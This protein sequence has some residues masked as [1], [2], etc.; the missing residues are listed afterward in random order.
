[1]T[2]VILGIDALDWRLVEDFSCEGLKLNHNR[3]LE[4]FSHSE[5]VPLTGEVWPSIAIGKH[6]TEHSSDFVGGTEWSSPVLNKLS[7]IFQ[8]IMPLSLRIKIGKIIEST[9]NEDWKYDR[10]EMTEELDGHVFSKDGRFVENWPGIHRTEELEQIWNYFTELNKGNLSGTHFKGLVMS[11]TRGQ[12]T[13][14]K[15]MSNYPTELVATHLHMIDAIG[16]YHNSDRN[17][18]R[19]AYRKCEKYVNEL[20]YSLGPEDELLILSDHGMQVSWIDSD[21]NPGSH[22][23][24]AFISSTSD[25][26]P[27]H[28]LGVR[29]WIENKVDSVSIKNEQDDI[30][31]DTLRNLGYIE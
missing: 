16:H 24:R 30:P 9:L 1:M 29:N 13:W 4:T 5:D 15:E 20:K 19:Q 3:K 23:F 21:T 11:K 31:E 26:P 6:P 25:I 7:G 14:C 22:S 18:Y 8:G 10:Q 2:L 17:Q 28:V 27:K 12:L